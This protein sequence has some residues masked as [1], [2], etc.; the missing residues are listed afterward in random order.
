L[1]YKAKKYIQCCYYYVYRGE[2]V[3]DR[4]LLIASSTKIGVII[5]VLDGMAYPE[6]RLVSPLF[7]VPDYSVSNNTSHPPNIC[8]TFYAN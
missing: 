7:S 5:A 6:L 2:L 3:R 8:P 1:I 4:E